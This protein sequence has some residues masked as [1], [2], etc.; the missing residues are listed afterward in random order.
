MKTR[1]G[2]KQDME[3]IH[4]KDLD[5]PEMPTTAWIFD[6]DGVLTTPEFK[7][8]VQPGL[9][10]ELV[11][12]LSNGE[13]V[14]LNTGRS[15][16]FIE[17]L[18]TPLE[19]QLA[20]TRLLRYLFAVGEKGAAQVSYD[21]NSRRLSRV[22][23][24]IAVPEELLVEVRAIA[25]EPVFS[26]CMFFDDTKQT[27]ISL[28]LREGCSLEEFESC[29]RKL[30]ATLDPILLKKDWHEHFHIDPTR[31]ATDIEH[32]RAGKSLGMA[33]IV[34]WLESN[35]IDPAQY[36]CFGDSASDYN[37]LEEL[38]RLGKKAR[39]VFVGEERQLAGKDTRHVT[40]TELPYDR[41]TLSY[42]RSNR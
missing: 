33:K 5:R 18:L 24:E 39:L 36:V 11:R 14:A 41:G 42:L 10:D 4:R 26:R 21:P 15:I 2:D 16:H 19:G 30:V 1:N 8:I 27:M 6:V 31:I 34:G 28:E 23:S 22:D 20:D 40:F 37:M 9:Y 35:S 3:W 17:G 13:P 32:R 7:R 25:E 29:Q 38:L 12:R